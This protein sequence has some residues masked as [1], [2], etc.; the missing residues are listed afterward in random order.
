MGWGL[1]GDRQEGEGEVG[2]RSQGGNEQK[3][4][5]DRCCR[6]ATMKPITL[7]ANFKNDFQDYCFKTKK[8]NIKNNQAQWLMSIIPAFGRLW[9]GDYRE[10]RANLGYN[11]AG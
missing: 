7:Y 3:Q 8:T 10:F 1:G 2:L 11:L 5:S 9:Q 4:F 6:N